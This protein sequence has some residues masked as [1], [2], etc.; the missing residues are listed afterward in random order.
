MKKMKKTKKTK[1]MMKM[2]KMKLQKLHS[3]EERQLDLA[4]AHLADTKSDNHGYPED[5]S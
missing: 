3:K 4:M 5:P 2:T 1:K